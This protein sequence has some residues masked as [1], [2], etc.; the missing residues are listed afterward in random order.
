MADITSGT[1][2][3]TPLGD[4]W[5]GTLEHSSSSQGDVIGLRP[6]LGNKIG[7]VLYAKS[8]VGTV[9]GSAAVTISAT[10]GSVTLNVVGAT[11]TFFVAQS[12][13]E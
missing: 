13:L 4:L 7:G 5:I 6:L 11:K 12:Q 9:A 2:R 1:V 3:A 10:S 8:D